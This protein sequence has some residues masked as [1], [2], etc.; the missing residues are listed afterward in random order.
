MQI[1]VDPW[2]KDWDQILQQRERLGSAGGGERL[3]LKQNGDHR[4]SVETD[5]SVLS[6]A[7]GKQGEKILMR[8][9]LV[10]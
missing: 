7:V 2:P 9:R 4:R 5:G 3:K 6:A 1:R 8:S 10:A